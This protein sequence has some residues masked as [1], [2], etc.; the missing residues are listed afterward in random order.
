M[1]NSWRGYYK[2]SH[3]AAMDRFRPDFPDTRGRDPC[4]LRRVPGHYAR[5]ADQH[6]VCTRRSSDQSELAD[7]QSVND[8]GRSGHNG[9]LA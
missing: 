5:S 9:Q 7:V 1:P 2:K 3:S 6:D 4:R 8:H